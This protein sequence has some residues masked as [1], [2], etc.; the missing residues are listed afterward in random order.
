MELERSGH[1][2][3]GVVATG[4]DAVRN[5]VHNRPDLVLMD[6]NLSGE[7]DGIEAARRMTMLQNVC[8]IF[9]T[10]YADRDLM[11]RALALRPLAYVTKPVSMQDLEPIINNW[12]QSRARAP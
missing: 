9:M 10:G 8:L 2:V 6:I 11:N 5:A 7:M 4:E 3:C 12:R 1:E